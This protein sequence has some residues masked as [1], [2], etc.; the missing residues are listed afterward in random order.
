MR[1]EDSYLFELDPTDHETNCIDARHYGNIARFINH[2]CKP[3]LTAVRVLYDHQDIRFPHIALF[4]NTT[5]PA[6]VELGYDYGEKFWV[7]KGT[8]FHCACGSVNCK[9][10]EETI[11]KTLKEYRD[12]S[13]H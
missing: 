5:I 12:R 4:A 10:N 2:L 3:N 1:E 8:K 7:V 11:G 9:Y 13:G 6:G